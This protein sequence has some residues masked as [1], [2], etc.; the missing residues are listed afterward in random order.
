MRNSAK[1]R[2]PQDAALIRLA[3]HRAI[4]TLEHRRLLSA[5]LDLGT[6]WADDHGH[7]E[8]GVD[9]PLAHLPREL[10]RNIHSVR[11]DGALIDAT[12]EAFHFDP[13]P[14]MVPQLLEGTGGGDGGGSGPSL[15]LP[16]LSSNPSATRKVFLDFDGHVVSGTPWDNNYN[17]GDPIHAPPYSVDGDLFNFSTTE[18]N[19]IEEVWRRVAEDFAPFNVDVTTQDPGTAAFTEG[20]RALRVLI[21]TNFDSAAM[22]GTGNQWFSNAGG[23]A[24]LG[25]WRWTSD[26]PVWVFE[27]NLGNGFAK[28]VAEAASHEVGHAFDLNHD[29]TSQTGY[30]RGHG[31][32]PTGWAPLM[33]VGYDR[34]LSQ[35]SKGEYPDANNTEDD[36]AEITKSSNKVTFRSDDVGNSIGSAKNLA[37]SESSGGLRQFQGEGII[38]TRTDVDVWRLDLAGDEGR[39]TL[40]VAPFF[41]LSGYNNLDVKADLLNSSGGVIQSVNPTNDVDAFFDL[42]LAGGTYFLRIDGVGKGTTST[43]YSDYGSI[44]QYE[45]LADWEYDEGTDAFQE[46]GGRVDFEAEDFTGQAAGTGNASGSNW[47]QFSDGAAG[48]GAGLIA[49]PNTGVVTGENT[50]GPR[51][52]Y[53][54]NFTNTGTY[55]VWVRLKGNNNVDDSI[56][57]GLDGNPVSLGQWGVSPTTHPDWQWI[58]KGGSAARLTVNVTTAGVHTLNM[59]MRE[60]GVNVDQFILTKDAN[61]HPDAGGGDVFQETGG[62]VD[63]EA[64]DFTGQAAGT[65]NASGSN[66]SQFSDGAAGGGA[67]LIAGPNTGVVTGD[68]TNGPR[69]DYAINFTNTGVYYVWVRIKGDNNLDDSIHVGLDGNPVSLGQWGVSPTTHPDWQ[70]VNKGGSSARLAINVTSAGVHQFNMWMREDGVKVDG[71]V[72]TK[73]AGFDPNGAQSQTLQFEAENSTGQAAGTGNASGSSWSQFSDGTASG[74][75]ALI[76]GPNTGVVT[77][78]ATNGPRRDYTM[79]FTRTGT[80]YVWVR[81]KGDNNVDD[82]IHVGFDGTPVSLGQWGVSPTTHPDWQWINKGG[83][84]ARLA[85]NVTSTGNHTFNMWMREDGVKVDRFILTTDPNFNPGA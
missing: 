28:Y 55:Y 52:D 83:S 14:A 2:S 85:V 25:S 32:G 72:L 42:D 44:G 49:G 47:S 65:G 48:G 41:F 58:N 18:I 16:I 8:P 45:I 66:W 3:A 64:E 23:V 50:N 46:S 74:G 43:G 7:T 80:Y 61:F 37:F 79:N 84:A 20:A 12:G 39:L 17:D 19:N 9:I 36:L 60:D 40:E 81:I 75:T 67:G 71:F 56:H 15:D 30:Y 10:A 51:R 53:A 76:A 78:E 22:G 63:F 29:G 73:D 35:W 68:A 1:T 11:D 26:T 33:G 5:N 57:V 62:R 69:R 82:S 6:P 21:S 4:E 34:A 77:G 38:T 31:S 59:W 24:Y 13:A 54:I 27:N 70:W